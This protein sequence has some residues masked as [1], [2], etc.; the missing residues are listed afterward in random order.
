MCLNGKCV[1]DHEN[2]IDYGDGGFLRRT[3]SVEI[4]TYVNKNGGY[5]DTSSST[6]LES[7]PRRVRT[8]AR[9]R[10]SVNSSA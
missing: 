10:Q 6:R 8:R 3:G 7:R 4:E 1:S 5:Q 2:A 9:A